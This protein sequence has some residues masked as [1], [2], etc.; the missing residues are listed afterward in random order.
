LG[1]YT[2]AENQFSLRNDLEKKIATWTGR[3][4]LWHSEFG[5]FSQHLQDYLKPETESYS[6]KL[7]VIMVLISVF[8][9]I[10]KVMPTLL[11]SE[12]LGKK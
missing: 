3:K 12:R 7:T 11:N 2:V 5:L 8:L 4:K 1:G 9:M 10:Q 6:F